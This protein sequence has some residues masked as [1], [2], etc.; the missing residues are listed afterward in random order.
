MNVRVQASE[1]EELVGVVPRRNSKRGLR[2]QLY[3]ALLTIDCLSILLSLGVAEFSRFATLRHA[4][5]AN[6]AIVIIPIYFAAA[7]NSGA[8]TVEVLG[9]PLTGIMRSIGS[10]CF[11]FGSLF[12]ILYFLRVGADI[13]RLMLAIAFVISPVA[14]T[15]GRKILG[16]LIQKGAAGD[17][18]AQVVITDDVHFS[19]PPTVK[20]LSAEA[21]GLRPDPQD[22]MM[23]HRLG[24]AIRNAD[25]VVIACNPDSQRRWAM[26][27]KGTNVRGEV[28]ASEFENT[29]AIGIDQFLGRATLVVST[30]PLSLQKRLVKRAFDLA[31]TIPIL[32]A[33]LPVFLLIAIAIKLDSRG[34]VLFKQQRIGRGNCLF[35]MY[36]FRS[37]RNDLT[38][39]RG[40]RSASRDD[41]RITRV[42]H[43]IRRTS[44]DELPQVLN[45]LLGSMSLVGPRPHALGSL[46]G[47]ALFWEV[48]ERYWHRH[49]LKPGITGLAQVRGFRGATHRRSDLTQRLQSDLEYMAGWSIWRDAAILLSTIRVVI[50]SNAY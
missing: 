5:W 44:L 47:D 28:I 19:V 34:P 14:I 45:V 42:G 41:D 1:H 11:A 21:H 25:R 8:Y 36:K 50:H 46:A 29:G 7:L 38:D 33:M 18:L 24:S 27:L 30:G 43:F 17:F 9:S 48:D 49:A 23:L 26:L 15:L 20:L 13:S 35:E 16:E 3:L 32:I 22:P 6:L 2:F 37:M 4:L 10:L 39:L 12:L 31:L 40:D